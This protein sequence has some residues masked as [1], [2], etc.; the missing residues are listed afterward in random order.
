MVYKLDNFM[1][2]AKLI[3]LNCI[4][5][6]TNTEYNQCYPVSNSVIPILADENLF[7]GFRERNPLGL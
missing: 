4:D 3:K 2:I 5:P 1:V 6:L 7:N